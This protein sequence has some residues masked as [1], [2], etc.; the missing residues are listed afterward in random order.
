MYIHSL[1]NSL[2]KK[3]IINTETAL[4]NVTITVIFIKKSG[5]QPPLQISFESSNTAPDETFFQPK[6]VDIFLVSPQN[7]TLWILIGSALTILM[8]TLTT[9]F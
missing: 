7:H 3:R 4:K 5:P 2:I 8:S 6:D 9:F 1:Y